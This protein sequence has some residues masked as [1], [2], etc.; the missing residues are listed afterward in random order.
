MKLL[1]AVP[2]IHKDIDP[3]CLES[4][5][6]LD[7]LGMS[8]DFH[9]RT[10]YGVDMQRNRIA[11]MALSQGYDWLLAVDSDVG[12]PPDALANLIEH[13]ADVCMG[14]YLNR[15]DHGD[16][17][18]TCLYAQT[19]GWEYYRASDLRAKRDA[20]SYTL[21]VR[22]GG[23]GCCLI[24]V[25]VFESLAFPWFVWS[26]RSFDRATGR[27]DSCGEDIDFCVKCEQAGIPIYADTRVEC[28]HVE[29]KA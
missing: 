27:V 23:L 1:V 7:K 25:G 10:G 9:V 16:S 5:E 4:V 3:P 28:A 21:R 8:W 22:G 12:L 17:E 11:A 14:W 2:Y 13:D 6:A 18:R 26:D 15:H 29:R 20:G 19:H 24:R